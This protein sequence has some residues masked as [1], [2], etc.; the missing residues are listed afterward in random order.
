MQKPSIEK[1]R[2]ALFAPTKEVN[3]LNNF[4]EAEMSTPTKPTRKANYEP[5]GYVSNL[6]FAAQRLGFYPSGYNVSGGP[7]GGSENYSNKNNM[8]GFFPDTVAGKYWHYVIG[9]ST[10]EMDG[11]WVSTG[12]VFD[13]YSYAFTTHPDSAMGLL[14][15][16]GEVGVSY[17]YRLDT[18]CA[19]LDYRWGEN[20]N[21]ATPDI[22][23]VTLTFFDVYYE[24]YGINNGGSQDFRIGGFLDPALKDVKTLL[25][26]Y[27]YIDPP[28]TTKGL[29]TRLLAAKNKPTI[30]RV[31]EYELTAKDTNV[32]DWP[33]YFRR[34]LIKIPIIDAHTVSGPTGYGY[35]VPAGSVLGVHFQYVP[36]FDYDF[37]PS[38]SERT[39]TFT[40]DTC[41]N[42]PD[43]LFFDDYG[44]STSFFGDNF[45]TFG[46]DTTFEV[47]D[48]IAFCDPLVPT[49]CDTLW[50]PSQKT[51]HVGDVFVKGSDIWVCEVDTCFGPSYHS[52]LVLGYD[53]LGY[54]RDTLRKLHYDSSQPD[55]VGDERNRK[56]TKDE[57][58]KNK[59][60][61]AGW[62]FDNNTI[63]NM[64]DWSGGVNGF[65]M[66][67]EN[68]RYSDSSSGRDVNQIRG[69]YYAT[70]YYLK[71][72]FWMVLSVGDDTVHIP[73][74]VSV[75]NYKNIISNVYPN[76]A[77]T[78][79]TINLNE[80]GNANV[81]IY[82][83]LGQIVI[84]ETLQN[85]SNNI[86]IAEL[87]SG[88]YIVRVN[89]SGRTHTVKISKK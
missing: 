22:L 88:L 63:D 56:F 26:M 79:L 15:E 73:L 44:F 74:P 42:A 17:G 33:G 49:D 83:I 47:N 86:N 40:D 6:T 37:I 32:L 76:P 29:T 10:R 20:Y 54:S 28:S 43:T 75:T 52:I 31:L 82:N 5:I 48:F 57:F 11:Y 62:D 66:E 19:Y 8:P 70:G 25:P 3:V 81:K 58:R 30:T 84:E 64:F 69:R 55:P 68:I 45:L 51:Y 53:T 89:Q 72:A 85:I 41:F 2:D 9:D 46:K 12:F 87:S 78:R 36:G 4:N 59:F 71:T 21:P 1:E 16:Y 60:S 34:S 61:M 50:F 35:T 77:T 39:H 13:P 80:A 14:R 24:D 23:R 67:T 18:L 65:F 27:E 7:G 38:V